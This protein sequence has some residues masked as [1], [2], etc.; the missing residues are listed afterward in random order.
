M[1][2]ALG[3]RLGGLLVV[4]FLVATM[5]FFL[6]R[7]APGDPA[8]LML[9]DQATA[10]DIARLRQ[11]YGLDRP[12][13]VQFGLW[14]KEVA[15][16]NLGQSIFLQRPVT[17]AIAERAE[18]T[19]FLALFAVSIAALVGIPAGIVS[20]VWRGRLVDQVVSGLAMLSANIPS[21]WL[22]LIFIQIFAV[23]LGW[24]PVAGYGAPGAPF[25]ERVVH[26]ALP[27]PL[28]GIVNSALITRFTRAR[29]LDVL[30]DDY[31]RTARSKGVSEARVVLRHALGNALV[32]IIT[33]VGLTAAL[34]VGGAIVTETVFGLPGIGNLV[35]SAV[36]R[37]DYPVIQ[38]ALI[39]VA[40]IY[41]LINLVVDVVYTLVD[42]RVRT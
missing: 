4:M 21:F 5:V 7:L 12:I 36:L 1:W 18:P 26:L 24:V 16:G 27:A 13:L 11:T 33:V 3:R 32:P 40:G 25:L 20:A 9:G 8:A 23:R 15:T 10:E 14:L 42:P 38:G 34:L 19:F 28:L 30:S 31:I 35:V 17:Q 2:L 22:G 39:V 6:T 37:R 41:V 29:M